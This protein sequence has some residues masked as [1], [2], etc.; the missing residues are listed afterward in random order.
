ME[1]K[2]NQ[3]KKSFEAPAPSVYKRSPVLCTIL[4]VC[5]LFTGGCAAILAGGAAG[6]LKGFEFTQN[7]IA[8]KSFTAEIRML[9]KACSRALKEM[10]IEASDP[11]RTDDGFRI[12]ALTRKLK[13]RIDI[14]H[15]THRVSQISVN[16]KKGI[17]RRDLATA[18]EIIRRTESVMAQETARASI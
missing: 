13:I 11:V 6:T 12:I 14:E 18:T 5:L 2:R 1:L 8:R 3:N 7:N 16:A 15:I 9:T 10:G 17:I 4:L